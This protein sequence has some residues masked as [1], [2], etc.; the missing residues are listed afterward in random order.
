MY[1]YKYM[2]VYTVKSATI[3]VHTQLRS[4]ETVL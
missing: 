2:Y 3:F 4:E 1:M